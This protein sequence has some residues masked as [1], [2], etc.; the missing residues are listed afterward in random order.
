MHAEEI[1]LFERR[2]AGGPGDAASERDGVAGDGR[3]E[4]EPGGSRDVSELSVCT[5]RPRGP[6]CGSIA[7]LIPHAV[8]AAAELE[9]HVRP[10]QLFVDEGGQVLL[11]HRRRQRL[12]A[13]GLE[14][15]VA[16]SK[17]HCTRQAPVLPMPREYIDVERVVREVRADLGGF[18]LV[19]LVAPHAQDDAIG[20]EKSAEV[21]AAGAQRD[22][23]PPRRQLDCAVFDDGDAIPHVVVPVAAADVVLRRGPRQPHVRR[24]AAPLRVVDDAGGRA[25]LAV[26]ARRATGVER[27]A[28]IAPL[29]VAGDAAFAR[30]RTDVGEKAALVPVVLRGGNLL[31]DDVDQAADGVGAVE[32]RRGTAHDLDLVRGRRVDR[33]AMVRRLARQIAC[34][35]AV[36]EDR[37]A[38]AVEPP[39]DGPARRRTQRPAGHAWLP[40]QRV[41]K[42]PREDLGQI[43]AGKHRRRLIRLERAP[44]GGPDR[45]D[46]L[47]VHLR[48][49]VQIDR[50][51][52]GLD[53]DLGPARRVPGRTH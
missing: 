47:V 46:L 34:A 22:L 1:E 36:L 24:R 25:D 20:V 48:V 32:Q 43:L 38:I 44:R 50:D 29:H 33:H 6:G 14:V 17:P 8:Q 41:A 15:P 9:R 51:R 26:A 30:A 31:V 45:H 2:V 12:V 7:R 40:V 42:R 4:Q 52:T 5:P 13:E 18:E 19:M 10:R 37:D 27:P 53:D 28:V 35:L 21:P 49:D 23:V 16:G 39:N 11:V 3:S